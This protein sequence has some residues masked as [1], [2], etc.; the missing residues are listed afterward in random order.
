MK[1]NNNNES[2]GSPET[3][4]RRK[5]KSVIAFIILTVFAISTGILAIDYLGNFDANKIPTSMI[6]NSYFQ[7]E[8]GEKLAEITIPKIV[9]ET[10]KDDPEIVYEN[11]FE[12]NV[13]QFY[14]EINKVKEIPLS[15]LDMAKFVSTNP[16]LSNKDIDMLISYVV[17]K[18][19]G[20][21][22]LERDLAV[23]KLM[24]KYLE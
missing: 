21:V 9:E 3:L 1:D 17:G 13:N 15:V 11:R 12:P 2:R 20:Y 22:D 24:E 5:K 19:R 10:A 8:S 23:E 6:D 16:T 4:D 7:E 14:D 18:E